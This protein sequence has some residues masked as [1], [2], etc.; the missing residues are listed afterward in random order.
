MIKAR[1]TAVIIAPTLAFSTDVTF[2]IG[3]AERAGC[4]PSSVRERQ[5]LSFVPD[6]VDPV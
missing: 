4:L 6:A 3:S 1:P 5:G 2:S